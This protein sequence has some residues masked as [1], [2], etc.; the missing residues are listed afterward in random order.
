MQ[1]QSQ[2]QPDAPQGAIPP[3]FVETPS[4]IREVRSAENVRSD[5]QKTL[6]AVNSEETAASAV[7]EAAIAIRAGDM[8]K[9]QFGKM[10]D[11][12]SRSNPAAFA[13][14]IGA[15]GVG[16]ILTPAEEIPHVGISEYAVEDE[17]MEGELTPGERNALPKFPEQDKAA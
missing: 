6:A 16:K 11:D 12:I 17:D 14:V 15:E 8:N 13:K 1:P 9:D 2:T 7:N 5:L 3:G 10:I 4:H